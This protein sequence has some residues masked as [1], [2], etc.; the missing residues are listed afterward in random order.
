[1]SLEMYQKRVGPHSSV[2]YVSLGNNVI[3]FNLPAIEKYFDVMV[4]KLKFEAG[5]VPYVELGYDSETDEIW[6]FPRESE[7]TGTLCVQ[8]KKNESA[9]ISV[10]GFVKRFDLQDKLYRVLEVRLEDEAIVLTITDKRIAR[11]TMKPRVTPPVVEPKDTPQKHFECS[12]CGYNHAG[13]AYNKNYEGVYH[14]PK[15]PKCGHKVFVPE[16][17]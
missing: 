17:K 16:R 11:R 15:C 4:E 6:V 5:C 8:Q 9:K 3:K 14:P 2:P 12:A 1:M 7:A 10:S 13:W